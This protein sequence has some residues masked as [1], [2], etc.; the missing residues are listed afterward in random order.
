MV[1]ESSRQ[2]YALPLEGG[3]VWLF[4][5]G[6]VVV[7]VVTIVIVMLLLLLLLMTTMVMVMVTKMNPLLCALCCAGFLA[8]WGMSIVWDLGVME[9]VAAGR[10]FA[11]KIASASVLTVVSRSAFHC[12][13]PLCYRATLHQSILWL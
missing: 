13:A 1:P 8:S 5:V 10:K 3:P 2:L 12:R 6:A 11:I 9:W 7:M 4:L